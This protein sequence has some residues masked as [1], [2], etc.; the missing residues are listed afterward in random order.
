M[1]IVVVLSLLLVGCWP[2]ELGPRVVASCS[3]SCKPFGMKYVSVERCE[4]FDS[5]HFS[6]DASVPKK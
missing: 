5:S 3:E 1:K 6:S 4:C 2:A